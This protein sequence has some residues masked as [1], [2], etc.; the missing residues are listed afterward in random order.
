MLRL[1]VNIVTN[2]DTDGGL[3]AMKQEKEVLCPQLTCI[4]LN[5]FYSRAAMFIRRKF[6]MF[7]TH[8]FFCFAFG[9][10]QI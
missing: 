1:S 2:S 6:K 9:V 4:R 3:R 10:N 7:Y 5:F 8:N